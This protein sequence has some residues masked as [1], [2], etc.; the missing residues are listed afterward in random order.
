MGGVEEEPSLSP[1]PPPK[2]H[3]SRKAS[4]AGPGAERQDSNFN[5]ARERSARARPNGSYASPV[6]LLAGGRR[7]RWVRPRPASPARRRSL[8]AAG[9]LPPLPL[10]DRRS[11]LARDS[12][13]GSGRLKRLRKPRRRAPSP[14]R[15]HPC[16]RT[17][18]RFP[19]HGRHGPREPSA[20]RRRGRGSPAIQL[21]FSRPRGSVQQGPEKRQETQIVQP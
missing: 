11:S 4:G 5:R 14:S 6:P 9:S 7:G 12:T 18:R 17:I 1:T 15:R 21:R 2:K 10:G 16:P 13:T 19:Q 20:K 8:A 3:R